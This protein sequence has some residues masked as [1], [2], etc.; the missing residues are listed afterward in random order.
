MKDKKEKVCEFGRITRNRKLEE[1]GYEHVSFSRKADYNPAAQF[2]RL[3]RARR[4]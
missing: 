2:G 1:S 3:T 4:G